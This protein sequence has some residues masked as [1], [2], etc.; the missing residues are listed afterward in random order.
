VGLP[1]NNEAYDFIRALSPKWTRYIPIVPTPKQ[2]LGLVLPVDEIFWGGAAGGG[3]SVWMLASALQWVDH[4]DYAAL[5]IRKNFPDLAQ[6]G[7]LMDMSHEWLDGTDAKWNE[8]NKR[9]YFPGGAT[10]SFG[11]LDNAQEIKRYRGGEYAFVGIDEITDLHKKEAMFLHSR[12]RRKA[13]SPIPMRFRAS[14]NPGGLGHD[15]VK[16]RYIDNPTADR[17]FIPAT[18]GDNPHID[19]EAYLRSLERLDPIT[20]D[21][22]LKGDWSL[23]EGGQLFDRAWFAGHYLDAP[24]ILVGGRVRAWDLAATVSDTSKETAGVL[25]SRTVK[26]LWVIEDVVHGKWHPGER[27]DVIRQTAEVDGRG[28]KIVIEEEPGSGGKAQNEALIR[29]LAGFRVE[30][31]RATG[32]KFV[33]AGAFASQVQAGNVYLVRGPWNHAFVE[34][35]HSAD[36]ELEDDILLDMMDASSMSFTALVTC[37]LN[38]MAVETMPRNMRY[39]SSPS[40]EREEEAAKKEDALEA[41]IKARSGIFEQM[42]DPATGGDD[43]GSLFDE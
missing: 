43:A 7:G 1:A 6:P 25:M 21:R 5:L 40:D 17:L 10:L 23:T 34:Q 38:P 2:H 31:V 41:R 36:P 14:S 18:L 16:S 4:R 32:S 19:Q 39:S 20:R 35:L 30:S 3:K 12:L 42:L 29:K 26:G 9:W 15:W 8:Q 27:D 11:H 33:R 13:G 37:T 24:P 28:V 22:L